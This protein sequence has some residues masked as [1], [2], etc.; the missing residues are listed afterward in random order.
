MTTAHHNPRFLRIRRSAFTLFELLITVCVIAVIAVTV[1]PTVSSADNL[2]LSAATS[3]VMSD[4]EYAQVLTMAH[5]DNPV[6]VVFNTG[7]S[8]YALCYDSDH[9]HPI[10]RADTNEPYEVLL[11]QGRASSASGVTFT[12]VDIDNGVL[13]FN[14]QGG[15]LDLS[16]RPYIVFS[17]AGAKLAVKIAPT[18]GTMSETTDFPAISGNSGDDEGGG[19]SR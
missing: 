10:N 4:I 11:G 3:I 13:S 6:V 5:P 2:R 7:K 8:T 16:R 19:K 12:L 14:E 18:T 15:V 9:L 17:S 1:I